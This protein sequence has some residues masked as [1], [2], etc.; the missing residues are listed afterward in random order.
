M[1]GGGRRV[2]GRGD[3]DQGGAAAAAAASVV[4][5]RVSLQAGERILW[6]GRW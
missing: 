4:K 6:V 3:M 2:R 1:G 5:G